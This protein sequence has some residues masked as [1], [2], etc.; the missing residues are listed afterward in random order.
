MCTTSY[1]SLPDDLRV[2]STSTS[3]ESESDLVQELIIQVQN[4]LEK[5][6]GTSLLF[7]LLFLLPTTA[8]CSPSRQAA[9]LSMLIAFA[10]QS[11]SQLGNPP[12][13][14]DCEISDGYRPTKEVVWHHV[15]RCPSRYEYFRRHST[16]VN[17]MLK[18]W[19]FDAPLVDL[20]DSC[21]GDVPGLTASLQRLFSSCYRNSK[22]K[23]Y[24]MRVLAEPELPSPPRLVLSLQYTSNE[25]T[26]S[27]ITL[28]QLLSSRPAPELPPPSTFL[29]NRH[30]QRGNKV[31]SDDVPALDRLFSS[32]R[33]ERSFQ[34]EYLARLDTSAQCVRQESQMSLIEAGENLI[35]ALEKH[36]AQCRV[37]Y[38]AGL[39]TLRQS[40]GPTTDPDEQVLERFGQWPPITAD[41]LLRYLASTSPVSLPRRWKECL[42]SLALLL[43][44]LQR[45]RRMLRFALDGLDEEFSKELENEGCDGWKAEEHPDWLLIQVRFL[46]EHMLLLR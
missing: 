21:C 43:L 27:R 12:I 30:W 42:V 26:P 19:P 40:L 15:G 20:L 35:E 14:A 16:V 8:Y 9:F 24:V 25:C 2:Q 4:I 41:V 44:N 31:S 36:Y 6:E 37:D 33:I 13:Y 38:M 46:S 22:L 29:R 34:R 3:D 7:Q 45:A 5:R 17:N 1:P 10:E 28:D 23:E 39:A 18:D 11:Q 32:L